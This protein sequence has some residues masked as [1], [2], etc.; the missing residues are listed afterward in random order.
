MLS[1]ANSSNPASH[2][3]S[4]TSNPSH[5]NPEAEKARRSTGESGIHLGLPP[6]L[7][8]PNPGLSLSLDAG[9]PLS[10]V[11][12]PSPLKEE[13]KAGGG[14]GGGVGLTLAAPTP[15]NSCAPSPATHA[16]IASLPLASSLPNP[17]TSQLS[18]S[19][20]LSTTPL[21]FASEVGAPSLLTS[22]AVPLLWTRWL[23]AQRNTFVEATPRTS[24][25]PGAA[26]EG[27]EVPNC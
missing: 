19:R 26:E 18:R 23:D 14:A 9:R 22:G 11:L 3:N 2:S 21:P 24:R 12:P 15:G 13:V 27:R 6:G 20:E 1:G 8:G 16:N 7:P 5:S 25:T 10:V 4:S 17:Q